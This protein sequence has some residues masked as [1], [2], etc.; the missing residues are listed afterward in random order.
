MTENEMAIRILKDGKKLLNE[1]KNWIKEQ[2]QNENNFCAV[3]CVRRAKNNLYHYNESVIYSYQEIY[4]G[5]SLAFNT[6]HR[7]AKKAGNCDV[8]GY[9]D[10]STTTYKDIEKIFNQS[11]KYLGG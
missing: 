4:Q 5:Y 1:G 8:I 11:I 9:N 6:L 7:F 3:G 10:R 2:Y